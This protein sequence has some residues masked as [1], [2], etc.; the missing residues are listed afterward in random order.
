MIER[1]IPNE[2]DFG[3]EKKVYQIQIAFVKITYI[4]RWFLW[5]QKVI[6]NFQIKI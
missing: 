5:K 3:F 6:D 2:V 1:S 4:M